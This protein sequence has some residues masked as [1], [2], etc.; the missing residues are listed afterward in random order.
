MKKYL[1]VLMVGLIVAM[2][3]SIFTAVI[4]YTGD[5]VEQLGTTQQETGQTDASKTQNESSAKEASANKEE[6]VTWTKSD[7]VIEFPILMY[8][9]I[10][11]V[12]DGNTLYV[13]KAEFQME[14]AALKE[15]GYYTL[16][17]EEAYRV[18][19]QNEK[20]AEKIVWVTLDDGYVDN[21]NS[22]VPVLTELG[23]K[24]TIN[25]I[26]GI[27][28]GVEWLAN[29]QLLELKK[30]ALIS[31]ESHTVDHVDLSQQTYDGQL[32]QLTDSRQTI[33]QLL[34]Q[35]TS[36]ICYPSGRYND[37]T[38]S[39]AAQAGYKLGL[40]TDPGLASSENGLFA[41][42]R[43]RIAYGHSKESFLNQIGNY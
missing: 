38:A 4:Y 35:D 9:H 30:N 27:Q 13:P 10:A 28:D 11:D 34:N 17:P 31:I 20:P 43:V 16:S 33:N 14:M 5:K 22:A 21:Y 24:A 7:T 1:T 41:L 23:M 2:F 29:P 18:L 39:V 6:T 15:A 3:A 25:V 42:N 12:V 37:E 32:A 36:V 19:T 40:T 26:T 8:H